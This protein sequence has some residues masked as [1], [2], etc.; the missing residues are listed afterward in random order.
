[1]HAYARCAERIKATNACLL[2][3]NELGHEL[4]RILG[5][6]LDDLD[7]RAAGQGS[8]GAP[9]DAEATCMGG[10]ALQVHASPVV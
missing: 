8:P 7:P 4:A 5:V 10:S 6:I 2:A 3:C 9:S 1:M